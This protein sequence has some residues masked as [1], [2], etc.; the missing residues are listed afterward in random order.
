MK[1]KTPK[2]KK[3]GRITSVAVS[4]L[5]NTGNYTNVRYDLAAEV[6]KG[7]S[8][9]ETLKQLVGILVALRPLTPPSCTISL[10]QARKKKLSER[11]EYEKEHFAQW[12]EEEM[13]YRFALEDRKEAVEALDS[14]GC[15]ASKDAKQS[16]GEE[17][18]PW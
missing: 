8:P 11:S 2:P 3:T 13:S 17:D 12:Q 18:T 16:W 14:M 15:S 10:K 6:P 9:S 1:K 4:R 7:S 5:Y